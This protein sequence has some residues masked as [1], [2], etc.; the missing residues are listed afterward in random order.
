MII[1][2]DQDNYC[3][4]TPIPVQITGTWTTP[5]NMRLEIYPAGVPTNLIKSPSLYA[6]P[7]DNSFY[8]DVAPWVRMCM[9]KLQ[10]TNSYT[11]AL[12]SIEDPYATDFRI[13]FNDS[14]TDVQTAEKTFVHCAL[15]E[16]YRST[17]NPFTNIRVWKCYP[18]SWLED[19]ERQIIIPNTDTPP[20]V[21]GTTV[22]YDITCCDG[23]YIKWLNEYGFYNYWLFPTNYRGLEREADEI[24]RIPRNIFD[25]NKTSNVDTAGFS[26]T[27]KLTV[28]DI[29][30]K[31][32]WPLM[33]SLVSSPEVYVLKNSWDIGSN[34]APED[35][36][37]IIQ[38]DG[39]FERSEFG[40]SSAEFEMEFDLP[41][42]YTQT[43]L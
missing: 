12:Q 29:I 25:P 36:I 1:G 2:L 20:S 40:R 34:V 5:N 7:T 17:E 31:R 11:T 6:S 33:K 39:S 10:N 19:G 42:I 15:S 13:D 9:A 35:W 4:H 16:G 18:F 3:V 21:S 8:I 24:Y 23:T 43:R 38:S 32:F 28:R 41:K 30:Y 37:Q 27:E 22:E 14:V 26:P